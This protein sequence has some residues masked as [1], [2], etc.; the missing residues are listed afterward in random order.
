MYGKL[1]MMKILVH[2]CKINDKDKKK[3]SR[4]IYCSAMVKTH[5]TV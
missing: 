5:G 4:E 3:S 1:V 2:K